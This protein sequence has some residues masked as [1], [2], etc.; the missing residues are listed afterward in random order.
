MVVE[1]TTHHIPRGKPMFELRLL[2]PNGYT[3][4]GAI[5]TASYQSECK[6]IEN[7]LLANEAV[8]HAATSGVG[9]KARNYRVQTTPLPARPATVD[10]IVQRLTDTT[11][12]WTALTALGWGMGPAQLNISDAVHKAQEQGLVTVK[13]HR[14]KTFVQIATYTLSYETPD[15]PQK[16]DA[17]RHNQ[18]N[19]LGR[20]VKRFA[21]R[22]EAWSIAVL[23]ST[24]QDV[25][26]RFACFG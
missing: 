4:P 19:I 3:V 10:D 1:P 8:E 22:K 20:V 14:G 2:D 9:Y 15:G 6:G 26:D 11:Y 18:V 12:E 24:D 17:L 5:R 23:D 13:E 7:A 16:R 21:D 25:T